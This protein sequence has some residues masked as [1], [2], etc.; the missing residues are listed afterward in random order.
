VILVDFLLSTAYNT[1]TEFL[2]ANGNDNLAFFNPLYEKL[3]MHFMAGGMPESVDKAVQTFPKPGMMITVSKGGC[4]MSQDATEQKPAEDKVNYSVVNLKWLR[5]Q[6]IPYVFIWIFYYAWVIA[7]TTWWTA[8]PL[9]ENVFSTQLRELMHSLTLVS[10]AAFVFIIRKEWFVKTARIGAVLII[11]GMSIFFTTPNANIQTLSAVIS[12]IAMGCVNISI[13][14]P[15]IFLLNNTEKL[16]AVVGSNLLIQL[17]SLF[18]ES[19]TQRSIEFV[20]SAAILAVSLGTIVFFRKNDIVE[21][22]YDPKPD[23]PRFHRR[24]YLSLLF[25]CAIAI[26]CKGVGKGIL[27][28]AA[29]S[30]GASVLTWYCVGG[31]AGCLL[32]ILI[33]TFTKKAYIWLGNM[34]FA[35]VAI[36]YMLNAFLHHI[37]ALTV[38]FAVL[39]GLGSTMGMINMYYILGV[40][41]KKYDSMRYVRLYIFF[42]GV[43]GGGSGI[44]VG[45]LISV[46]GTLELPI[47]ASIFSVV[48]M[49]AF[50]FISPI[51]ERADYVNVW[52]FDSQQSE[53]DNEQLHVF[54]KYRLSKREI[55]VCKLLLQGY[56]MRQIS[57]ILSIAYPT[58]NTYCTSIYRKTKINSRSELLQVFK[59]YTTNSVN[60]G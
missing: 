50:M 1:F 25:N 39:L 6:N 42:I 29:E 37:Q 28:V 10:S 17:L 4:P 51:M 21:Y 54:R 46:G 9:T 2:I 22:I 18:L 57:G 35:S 15:F 27:N 56:T 30:A 7:F 40:I 32:Y 11:T 60:T 34:T 3:K 5:R 24:I 19:N 13:L 8:S 53:I 41:G 45:S 38:P 12:S 43:F 26:L 33:Y 55:Q 36:S 59:D 23:L 31:L 49:I 44:A 52:G 48:V 14:I 20:L 47:F 16:Y 58:V